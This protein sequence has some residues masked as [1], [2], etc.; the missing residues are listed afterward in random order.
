LASSIDFH[1]TSQATE[2]LYFS[3]I[4]ASLVG[5]SGTKKTQRRK[6]IEASKGFIK[7]LFSFFTDNLLSLLNLLTPFMEFRLGFKQETV[8]TE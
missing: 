1:H 8:I 3:H 6:Q 4:E 5:F 2:E 7:F